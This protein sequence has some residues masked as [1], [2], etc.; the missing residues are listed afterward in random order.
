[1]K[2]TPGDLVPDFALPDQ[3]GNVQRLSDYRGRYVVV[4]VYPKDDTPGCTREACDFR[5]AAELRALG[6]A[7]LGISRDDS[8]SHARFDGKYGLGFP[9]LADTDAAVIRS[10]GA[11]GTKNMYGKVSEGPRR[12]TFI[13]GP[14]GH[15]VR[16][17]YAVK[18]DGHADAVTRVIREHQAR[19]APAQEA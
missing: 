13:V 4:Y 7:V 1:M 11:W 14:D 8:E 10:L 9:L 12:S 18:V 17:W 3:S 15:L 16:A 5:D 6:A 19:L 2:L